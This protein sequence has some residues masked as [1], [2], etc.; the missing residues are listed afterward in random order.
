V[1]D[2]VTLN[3]DGLFQ[4]VNDGDNVMIPP[5]IKKQYKQLFFSIVRGEKL[6]KTDRFGTIDAYIEVNQFKSKLKSS[7]VT[8]SNNLVEWNQ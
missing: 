4:L 7:V 5:S 2:S 6:P 3:D 8:M 1:D